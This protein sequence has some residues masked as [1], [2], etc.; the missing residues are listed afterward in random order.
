MPATDRLVELGREHG[1][2]VTDDRR[3]RGVA[4]FTRGPEYAHLGTD[5][6]GDRVLSASGGVGGRAT[7]HWVAADR[8]ISRTERAK[9]D[10]YGELEKRLTAEPYRA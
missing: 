2:T 5:A 8:Y 10:R 1:W 6:E 3:E 4:W 9:A 7:A